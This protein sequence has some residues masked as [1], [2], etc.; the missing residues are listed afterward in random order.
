MKTSILIFL[1][2][3][4][5][6]AFAEAND[7]AEQ[8]YCAYVNEQAAA[9]RDLLRTP[10]VVGGPIQPNT[11]TP[12]QMV[13]G[14][15]SSLSDIKKSKLTMDVAR[16][17]CTLYAASAEA[18]QH[19]LYALPTIE[20]DVLRHRLTL[21]Q[22]GTEKLDS[23]EAEADKLVAAQ[24]LTRPSAYYLQG[25]RI[26]LDESRTA[27]LTGI[28][29]PYVPELSRV[30]LRELLTEKMVSEGD[31]EKA[32]TRLQKQAG[33]DIEVSGGVRRQIGDITPTTKTL[34]GYGTFSLN[35]D[36][37]R[38]AAN[39]H[40]DKSVGAY[41]DWKEHQFDDVTTQAQILKKQIED[42]ITIQQDQLQI[43][44]AHNMDIQRQLDSLSGVDTSASLSFRNQLLA[45][46]I[47]LHVEIGDAQ[48]RVAEL[49]QYLIDN[50]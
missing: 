23:L 34:G 8:A 40:E 7:K 20:K 44:L 21:I 42:T 36:L 2:L 32:V 12:P 27:A 18:Q 16:T 24:N 1:L 4:T 5:A 29:S 41:I 3:S 48:F 17:N 26:R 39:R 13:I 47:V 37:G 49:Q 25:A 31:N 45:D 33:W 10:S 38:R 11:G 50:F 46:Q 28:A 22:Q 9:Q 15:T 43:L 35:Y 6:T 14:V 30:P 19:I